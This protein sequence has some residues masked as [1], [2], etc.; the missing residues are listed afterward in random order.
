MNRDCWG[1][2]IFVHT[3]THNL[4]FEQNY[5]NYQNFSS[6]RFQFLVVKFSIYLNRRVFVMCSEMSLLFLGYVNYLILLMYT[7]NQSD[8]CPLNPISEPCNAYYCFY[9][10]YLNT[11][12]TCPRI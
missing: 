5:E 11:Y 9:P 8:I 1:F 2:E 12:H 4:C 7:D 10:K 6:V 3:N